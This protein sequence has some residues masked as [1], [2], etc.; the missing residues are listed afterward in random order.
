M[1]SKRSVLGL[2]CRES[3]RPDDVVGGATEAS[4]SATTSRQGM[5]GSM[6]PFPAASSRCRSSLQI[7]HQAG[8]DDLGPDRIAPRAEVEPIEAVVLRVGLTLFSEQRG[9]RLDVEERRVKGAPLADEPVRSLSLA[10]DLPAPG[11]RCDPDEVD[12]NSRQIRPHSFHEI[13]VALEQDLWRIWSSRDGDRWFRRRQ[14]PPGGRRGSRALRRR[15]CNVGQLC[16]AEAVL[17]HGQ[18]LHIVFEGRP[19]P[20]A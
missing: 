10:P 7:F 9:T 14:Q 13:L 17:N 20:N 12:R 15:T 2:A 8:A 16:A 3:F 1:R 6:R 11:R 5:G 18:W 19:E 4:R